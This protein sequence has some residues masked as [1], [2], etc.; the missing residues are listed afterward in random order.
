MCARL[1]SRCARLPRCISESS[2]VARR[3]TEVDT[4][5]LREA[6]AFECANDLSRPALCSGS[7]LKSVRVAPGISAVSP[8]LFGDKANITLRN[9]HSQYCL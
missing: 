2:R 9:I 1:F 4:A 7:L 6:P 3:L 8:V 5:A